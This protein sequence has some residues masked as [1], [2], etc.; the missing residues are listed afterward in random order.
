MIPAPESVRRKLPVLVP[1][2][3]SEN[4]P[5]L[6]VVAVPVAVATEIPASRCP[7]FVAETLPENSEMTGGVGAGGAGGAEGVAGDEEPQA[8]TKPHRTT[9]S[10]RRIVAQYSR[11]SK[12]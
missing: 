1:L 8:D 2:N 12:R 9:A 10:I 6:S 11:A 7:P 4:A 3:F 5:P